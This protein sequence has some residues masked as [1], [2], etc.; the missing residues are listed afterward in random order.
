LPLDESRLIASTIEP[1]TIKRPSLQLIKND[2]SRGMVAGETPVRAQP[3]NDRA[4]PS[5][6]PRLWSAF[7]LCMLLIVGAAAIGHALFVI[8]ML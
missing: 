6:T 2:H 1:L 7:V 5:E 8:D 4:R 3:T